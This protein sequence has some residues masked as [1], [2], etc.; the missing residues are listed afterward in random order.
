MNSGLGALA[1]ILPL[2]IL[3]MAVVSQLGGTG[4][5]PRNGFLGLRIPSTL[6]SDDAWRAGHRAAALPA[7]CGFAAAAVVA[8][9]CWTLIRSITAVDICVVVIGAL[10]GVT[11]IWSL[12]AASRA[13]RPHAPS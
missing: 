13:A 12:I 6:A 10:F 7:W 9:V 4:R 3:L 8:V 5:L 11:V 2:A 1:I